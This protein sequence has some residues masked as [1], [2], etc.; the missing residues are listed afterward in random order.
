MKKPSIFEVAF[1]AQ[2]TLQEYYLEAKVLPNSLLYSYF[3]PAVNRQPSYR[4]EAAEQSSLNNH[5]LIKFKLN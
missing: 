1:S 5:K 4:R 3:G 2:L